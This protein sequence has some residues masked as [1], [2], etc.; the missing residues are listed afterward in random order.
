MRHDELARLTLRSLAYAELC[1]DEIERDGR[2]VLELLAHSVERDD[3]R[4]LERMIDD[5]G[6]HA[7]APQV[8]ARPPFLRGSVR[9][10]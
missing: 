10:V 9:Y 1:T 2:E 6:G 8:G 4:A 3:G 5:L 7:P